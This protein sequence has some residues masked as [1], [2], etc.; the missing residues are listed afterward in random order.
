MLKLLSRLCG[1]KSDDVNDPTVRQAYGMMSGILGIVL[2]LLLAFGKMTVG[3]LG[4]L[5]S[6]QADA[7]NNLSDAGSS[8]ISLVSFRISAKPADREHPF[9]HARVE[10][11]AGMA[12]SFLIL[13]IGLELMRNSAV[14][15]YQ[16]IFEPQAY[17]PAAFSG[18]IGVV[19]LLSVLGKL[20][21][22][23]VN[24][25]LGKK[26]DSAV[27]RAT[28]AD[29]LS[30][31][32]S[33]TAVLVAA[34]VAHFFHLPF[35]LDG[36]MGMLVSVLILISGI[37]ILHETLDSILGKAPSD[38]LVK[39]IYQLVYS[40][41]G[42]CGAHDLRVHQYGAGCT[43]VTLHVEVDGAGD[44]F[45]AHDMVDNMEL[46]LQERLHVQATVHLDP[47][48]LGDPVSDTLHGLTARIAQ[49]IDAGISVHDF[50]FVRGTTHS[51]LIFDMAVP[52]EVALSDTEIIRKTEELLQKE[53]ASY[54]AR[55]HVDR[56]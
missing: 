39:S 51:N 19:L 13:L 46:A 42:V 49:Q 30:D 44:F 20:F 54:R 41:P 8:I 45:A 7:V 17:Q 48:V 33:T 32:M 28:A 18:V 47:I 53:N 1:N 27:M 15:L 25:T 11:V 22:V 26:L 21:L 3:V 55:I 24:R 2:N 16:S 5:V 50:R 38:E 37:K 34:V 29:S 43:I 56:V 14:D 35:S 9:G 52:F 4:G 40:F 31:A 23:Y 36:A 12:V 10:Y 6:V